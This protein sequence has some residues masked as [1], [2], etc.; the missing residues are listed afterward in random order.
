MEKREHSYYGDDWE[1][2]GKEQSV[3]EIGL[4]HIQENLSRTE[5]D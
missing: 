2:A 4:E 5:G 1:C 3:E